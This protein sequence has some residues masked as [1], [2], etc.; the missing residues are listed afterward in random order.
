MGYLYLLEGNQA[1]QWITHCM[2]PSRGNAAC[3]ADLV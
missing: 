1:P 3:C 2:H